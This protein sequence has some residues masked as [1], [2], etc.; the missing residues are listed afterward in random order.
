MTWD[1]YMGLSPEDIEEIKTTRLEFQAGREV[2]LDFEVERITGRDD[3][4][5]LPLST[6]ETV[7]VS[8]VVRT[9]KDDDTLLRHGGRVR[10]GDLAVVLYWDVAN[11]VGLD[12]LR[13]A[14]VSIGSEWTAAGVRGRRYLVDV[15]DERGIGK[16]NRVELGLVLE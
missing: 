6:T 16:P 15:F 8:G 7:T 1:D 10:A 5:G 9:I 11:S 4:T 12:E 14:V 2:P 13:E 3:F